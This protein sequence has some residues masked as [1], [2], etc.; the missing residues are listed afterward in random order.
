MQ[1]ILLGFLPFLARLNWLLAK[2]KGG[3]G[4]EGALLF[5]T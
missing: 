2:A 3:F 1:E 5:S 4:I